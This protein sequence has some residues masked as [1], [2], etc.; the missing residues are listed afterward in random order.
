M[1]ATKKIKLHRVS[2]TSLRFYIFWID[3]TI[4]IIYFKNCKSCRYFD[5]CEL[6]LWSINFFLKKTCL[7]LQWKKKRVWID[8][9]RF[10]FRILITLKHTSFFLIKPKF[11]PIKKR[12]PLS[13]NL[14]S[15]PQRR[16]LISGLEEKVRMNN[17]KDSHHY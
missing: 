13:I 14:S 4:N 11:K 9:C 12:F 10:G 8:S 5:K 16:D 7:H 1:L 6:I 2:Y 15:I 3:S 17:P